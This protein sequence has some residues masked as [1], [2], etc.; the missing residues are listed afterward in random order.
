MY[1]L[2]VIEQIGYGDIMHSM[3]TIVNIVLYI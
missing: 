2:L 1:K 3:E